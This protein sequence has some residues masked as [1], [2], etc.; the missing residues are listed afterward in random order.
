MALCS[1]IISSA[2][3]AEKVDATVKK[4]AAT[5]VD[6]VAKK[7]VASKGSITMKKNTGGSLE[8]S[9]V[10]EDEDAELL[11]ENKEKQKA[12]APQTPSSATDGAEVASRNDE[13][14]E[15]AGRAEQRDRRDAQ[16]GE[17]EDMAGRAQARGND[18]GGS[19][20]SDDGNLSPST[21][22]GSASAA[23]GSANSAGG[24]ALATVPKVIS[25][26]EA[27]DAQNNEITPNP[28][29]A[30]DMA[31]PNTVDMTNTAGQERYRN[32]MAQEAARGA[33]SGTQAGVNN[34]AAV[35]RYIATDRATYQKGSGY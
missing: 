11:V 25:M 20:Y 15:P 26:P 4:A 29:P 34:P 17:N 14:R 12:D 27:S 19:G 2:M 35:R 33:A 22:A 21:A 7:P 23:A 5:N 28:R 30:T 18:Q 31:V 1:S 32:L 9:N 16:R 10:D 8:L 24:S 3:A 6:A 13:P